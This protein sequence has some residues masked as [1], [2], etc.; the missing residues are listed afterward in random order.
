MDMH[1]IASARESARLIIQRVMQDEG[2][3]GQLRQ[4]PRGTLKGTGFP[5]W[6]LDDFVTHDLGIEPDVAGYAMVE[7]GVTILLGVDGDGLEAN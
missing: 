4:D 3:A 6:A 1:D 5:E 7:C 2:F